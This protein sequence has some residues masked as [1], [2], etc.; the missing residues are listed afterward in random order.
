PDRYSAHSVWW[1]APVATHRHPTTS[2]HA[3]WSCPRPVHS[4][5]Q[6][7]PAAHPMTTTQL[8]PAADPQWHKLCHP[9]THS[10]SL[11]PQYWHL[12]SPETPQAATWPQPSQLDHPLTVVRHVIHHRRTD[13]PRPGRRPRTPLHPLV[14]YPLK[15]HLGLPLQLFGHLQLPGHRQLAQRLILHHRQTIRCQLQLLGHHHRFQIHPKLAGRVLELWSLHHHVHQRLRLG[16]SI[17]PV[18]LLQQS[19]PIRCLGHR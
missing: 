14:D 7:P 18:V 9:P 3:A 12:T 1:H 15:D 5:D 8:T 2:G 4:L 13:Q 10:A 11:T 17:Q 6:K 16:L 19:P